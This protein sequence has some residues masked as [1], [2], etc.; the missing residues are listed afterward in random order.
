M[1]RWDTELVQRRRRS[2]MVT[3]VDTRERNW[4]RGL[5]RGL[6]ASGGRV[7]ELVVEELSRSRWSSK[8][9]CTGRPRYTPRTTPATDLIHPQPFQFHTVLRQLLLQV[10]DHACQLLL[11]VVLLTGDRS[12]D[13]LAS[14]ASD[15]APILLQF[16]I[17]QCFQPRCHLQRFFQ[18]GRV[19]LQNSQAKSRVAKTLRKGHDFPHGSGVTWKSQRHKT[20][21]VLVDTL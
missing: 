14:T 6:P 3:T 8:C 13:K 2:V 9:S 16:A 21:D 12:F 15:I 19:P 18:S 7:S 4:W 20:S 17:P 5:R 10:L 1:G 11:L